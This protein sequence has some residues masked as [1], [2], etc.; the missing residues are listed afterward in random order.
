MLLVSSVM[1]QPTSLELFIAMRFTLVAAVSIL[2]N[3]NWSLARIGIRMTASRLIDVVINYTLLVH[4][5]RISTSGGSLISS[6]WIFIQNLDRMIASDCWLIL[7]IWTLIIQLRETSL[8]S[9]C[10]F[11][12]S[13]F[14]KRDLLRHKS[15]IFPSLNVMKKNHYM[16]SL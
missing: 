15:Q 4:I 14:I 1:M 13:I 7:D 11:S 2:L 12:S 10:I 8:S 6:V 3:K 5:T 9:Y 16:R